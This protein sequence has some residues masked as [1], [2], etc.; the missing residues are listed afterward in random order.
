MVG[1][2]DQAVGI[3]NCNV[4]LTGYENY[5]IV[6]DANGDFIFPNVYVNNDYTLNIYHPDYSL[7]SD[8]IIIQNYNLDLGVIVIDEKSYAPA[9]LIK[10]SCNGCGTFISR[11]GSP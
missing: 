2:D 6:T 7:Y 11:S 5:T 8:E 4:T 10:S 3:E 1:S 9:M